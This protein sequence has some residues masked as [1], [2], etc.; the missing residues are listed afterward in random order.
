MAR[1]GSRQAWTRVDPAGFHP[2]PRRNPR[3]R[4]PSRGASGAARVGAHPGSRPPPPESPRT[5]PRS[6]SRARL[7]Q[8]RPESA[9]HLLAWNVFL[10]GG[11]PPEI[12]GRVSHPGAPVP[13]ELILRLG[14]GDRAGLQG[15][16]VGA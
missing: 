11:D 8:G 16:P 12:A 9:L 4:L 3:A 7:P 10:V 13:V 14:D 5:R 1:T 15:A 6:S 2:P